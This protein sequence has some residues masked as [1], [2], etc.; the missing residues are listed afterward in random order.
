LALHGVAKNLRDNKCELSRVFA[1]IGGRATGMQQGC[2][3]ER[4]VA[5]WVSWHARVR[6]GADRGAMRLIVKPFAFGTFLGVDHI[7]EASDANRRIRTF[8][9]AGATARALR[10]DDLVRHNLLS[11]VRNPRPASAIARPLIAR[12]GLAPIN[13]FCDLNASAS[14]PQ[15][16]SMKHLSVR[17]AI[18]SRPWTYSATNA[19]RRKRLIIVRNAYSKDNCRNIEA[20][21]IRPIRSERCPRR[22]R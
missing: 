15:L 18:R 14:L 13:E 1:S 16:V 10:G 9:L 22:G 8:Q 5:S 21:I 4:S 3:Q 6:H 17:V 11:K 2:N 7:S 20:S 19:A 12:C